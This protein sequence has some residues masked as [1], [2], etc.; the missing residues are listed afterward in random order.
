MADKQ[1]TW[2]PTAITMA[3]LMQQDSI[4]AEAR[5]IAKRTLNHQLEQLR[6][7]RKYGVPVGLGTDSGSNG[8]NHGKA[9]WQEMQLYNSAGFNSSDTVQCASVVNAMLL[10][11]ND[12]GM[13]RVGKK[14]TF[15][16]DS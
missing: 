11:A 16:I 7:A 2:I 15:N 1:I 14:A 13:L 5:D 6:L 10:Q 12:M 3:A 4:S 9:V 8:V